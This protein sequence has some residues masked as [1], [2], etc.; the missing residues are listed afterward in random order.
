MAVAQDRLTW[1]VGSCHSN[2]ETSCETDPCLQRKERAC[3]VH[4]DDLTTS[5]ILRLDVLTSLDKKLPL[6]KVCFTELLKYSAENVLE[7]RQR[8]S[9]KL[10]LIDPKF[11]QQMSAGKHQNFI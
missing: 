4:H 3:E 8:T 5:K 6:V 1:P 7:Q 11:R 9:S 2:A 10:V